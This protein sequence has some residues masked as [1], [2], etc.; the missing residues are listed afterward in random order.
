M[1]QLV[2][3]KLLP[4]ALVLTG[5]DVQHLIPAFMMIISDKCFSVK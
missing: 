1:N 5:I 2:A 3:M 4:S